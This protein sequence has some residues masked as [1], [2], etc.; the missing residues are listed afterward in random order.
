MNVK[1]KK[2]LRNPPESKDG[3]GRLYHKAKRFANRLCASEKPKDQV[4]GI[5]IRLVLAGYLLGV[6]RDA[7]YKDL[8]EL[9]G[10]KG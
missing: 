5:W 2:P 9:I 6:N 10:L 3:F 8:K 1:E 7:V 4:H